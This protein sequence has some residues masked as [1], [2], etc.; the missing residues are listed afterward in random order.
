MSNVGES[1][2]NPIETMED[3]KKSTKSWD[4]VIYVKATGDG[5]QLPH[6]CV[7]DRIT[8]GKTYVY[9]N[10]NGGVVSFD[11]HLKTICQIS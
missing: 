1:W 7:M 2:E 6:G 9:W 3:C 4:D 8:P 5:K 11:S 10:K